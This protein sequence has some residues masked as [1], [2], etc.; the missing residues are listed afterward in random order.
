MVAGV[1]IAN[2][3]I[4]AIPAGRRGRS[5]EKLTRGVRSLAARTRTG[6]ARRH[7]GRRQRFSPA[8]MRFRLETGDSPGAHGFGPSFLT[9]RTRTGGGALGV[10]SGGSTS[11]SVGMPSPYQR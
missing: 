3:T 9:V 5:P 6:E 2:A 4:E 8:M 1:M 7:L 10:E 11:R